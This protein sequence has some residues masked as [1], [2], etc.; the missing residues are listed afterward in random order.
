MTFDPRP[1]LINL[2]GKEYLP[3]AFRIEWFRDQHPKGQIITELVS[4][5][6]IIMRATIIS[7]EGGLLSTGHGSATAKGN[8][9]WG[10]REIEKAETAAIGRA[11]AHAGYGTQFTDEDEDVVDSP[12]QKPAT[13]KVVSKPT[14]NGSKVETVLGAGEQRRM[15]SEPEDKAIHEDAPYFTSS[16]L[17][18]D[19]LEGD[20]AIRNVTLQRKHLMNTIDLLKKDG[21]VTNTTSMR[22]LVELI[23]NREKA[24]AAEL[25][26]TG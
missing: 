1:H 11:L 24:K 4:A 2:K 22:A 14:E 23:I 21:A 6:P 15:A 10:G 16:R 25:K 3:V 12:V 18:V 26:P 7:D 8:A 5:D 9:V 17:W 20:L 19:N 13:P